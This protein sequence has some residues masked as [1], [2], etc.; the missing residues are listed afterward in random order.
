[1]YDLTVEEVH[2]FAIGE[3]DWVVHNCT[4][5]KPDIPW[6]GRVT[7]I[8]RMP[9]LENIFFAME[10]AIDTWWKSGRIPGPDDRMVSRAENKAWLEER[11]NRGDRFALMSDP[12]TLSDTR[13]PGV[14]N[15]YFTW[16][17]TQWLAEYGITPE[18]WW[19]EGIDI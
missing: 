11:I 4:S 16:L 17:E 2:T 1:M 7:V 13:V 3:G 5:K 12:N 15:G 10:D 18:S 6:S 14:P 9:D 19:S 8:G